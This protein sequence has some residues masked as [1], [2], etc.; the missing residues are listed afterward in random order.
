MGV[1]LAR[2]SP[3]EAGGI[4][5]RLPREGMVK[6]KKRMEQDKRQS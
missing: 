6:G 3:L 1:R 2:F 4:F 5:A